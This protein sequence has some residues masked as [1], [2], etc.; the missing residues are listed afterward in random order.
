M[1]TGSHYRLE[2]T[3]VI[4]HAGTPVD[5]V[6][7]TTSPARAVAALREALEQGLEDTAARPDPPGGR[8]RLESAS[9]SC[10]TSR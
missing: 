6:F 2:R 7:V 10:P 3:R 8:P 1:T 5:E 9:T 4:D